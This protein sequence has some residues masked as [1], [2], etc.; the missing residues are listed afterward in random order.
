MGD[1]ENPDSNSDYLLNEK[2]N[3][4]ALQ[5]QPTR[6]LEQYRNTV[7]NHVDGDNNDD[8]ELQVVIEASLIAQEVKQ[9]EE[10][11]SPLSPP[12]EDGFHTYHDP[13]WQEELRHYHKIAATFRK[14][15]YIHSP[16]P[17]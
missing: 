16:P 14:Y 11:E 3:G 12:P 6:N 9:T 8:E 5:V 15:R 1:S 13:D 4:N 2:G 10:L 17:I 7:A